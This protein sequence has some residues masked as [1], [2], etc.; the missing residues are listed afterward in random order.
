MRI[1]LSGLLGGVLS[2]D[3]GDDQEAHCVVTPQCCPECLKATEEDGGAAHAQCKEALGAMSDYG[4]A[5]RE[6]GTITVDPE[7]AKAY[8]VG[9]D[10]KVTF[11]QVQEP[12]T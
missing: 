12:E 8:R 5:F 3:D 9:L 2:I 11:F 4:T 7:I 1:F 10:L 6:A